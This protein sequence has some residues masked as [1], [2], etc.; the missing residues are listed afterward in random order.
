MVAVLKNSFKELLNQL[1]EVL[2]KLQAAHLKVK[3]FKGNLIST[4]VQ[5]L[6]HVISSE[7]IMG[8]PTKI[9]AI[10]IWSERAS[11]TEVRSFLG[12]AS[13]HQ[14]FVKNYAEVAQPLH[15]LTEKGQR[16]K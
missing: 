9:E 6:G 2:G 3:P 14:C 10:R 1:G 12:L 4:E 11:Q 7:G 16:C 5:Y 8:A 13:Y 15:A